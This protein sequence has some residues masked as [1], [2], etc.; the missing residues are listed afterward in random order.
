MVI[1]FSGETEFIQR[2][3]SG[4]FN[5]RIHSVFNKVINIS[6]ADNNQ[7]YTIGCRS[8]DNAPN[9]LV[10]N[11]N[12]LNELNLFQHQPVFI[13]HNKL[14][15]NHQLSVSFERVNLWRCELPEYISHHRVIE[16][17]INLLTERIEQQ[18]IGG[19]I[20]AIT[21][22]EITPF[23]QQML[24]QLSLAT[25]ELISCL[26]R[27]DMAQIAPWVNRCVGLGIGLTPA[28]DDFLVGLCAVLAMPGNPA[29]GCLSQLY[30]AISQCGSQTNPIS[31]MAISKAAQGLV[32][33]SI[34]DLLVAMVGGNKNHLIA[35]ID[36][37][38]KIGS[39]SGT[40][41]ATGMLAGLEL[42]QK[43]GEATCLQ[44]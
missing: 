7:L 27:G 14:V 30:Q 41:I 16:Q 12:N 37:V 20:K 33:E 32:R 31:Y 39:T 42:S 10:I 11:L 18:G 21:D 2:L 24:V 13:N 34:V 4:R 25:R 9:T 3:N 1:A 40:D 15:V 22:R 17:S 5:G 43:L 6:D 8:V 44:K 29:R 19:G 35:K 28:G 23:E 38:L 26:A 36:A